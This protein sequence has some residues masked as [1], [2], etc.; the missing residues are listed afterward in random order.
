MLFQP[1]IIALLLASAL[2]VLALAASAPFALEVIRRWDITSGS[3]RQLQLERR[4]YLF[5]TLLSFVLALQLA[6]VLLF[7][8]NAEKMSGM[9]VGAM[10]AVGT[11]NVNAFGFPAL[12]AKIAVFFL[13]AMWLAINH[14]DSRARDYPLVRIK[15]ALLLALAPLLAASAWIELQY[16]LG[17][18]A[19][20]IT[21][22]CGSLF[23]EGSPTLAAEASAL[24][25][26]PAM[27]LFYGSLGVAIALAAWHG[28]GGGR[29]SA[30]VR[31]E[32]VE[33]QATSTGSGRAAST[34]SGQAASTRSGQAASTRSGQA[35][36]ALSLSGPGWAER[37]SGYALAAA[38]ALAFAAT[39]AGI[40]SFISLYIYEHPNHHCPFC[41]L[42]PEYG[43][44][45][46]W[47][48]VPL[49]A[50]TAAGLA[51]GAI[52]PF[53]RIASLR[54]IVPGFSRTLAAIAANGFALT[55]AIA[56]VMIW[57]SRLILLEH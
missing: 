51:V 52:Q 56:T 37:S 57:Q 8:F 11:L 34:R 20:V 19:D 26:L 44:Q 50:A 49:F 17:L 54:G 42:K 35:S 45:G 40:L 31:P 3:E 23:S 36:T 6:A 14:I 25:P 27:W 46:Y 7:V 55:A 24:S 41:I 10:C 38:S 1:A 4:T 18:K 16:F 32:P 43:Y 5:S 28:Y 47:L 21:S 22:C 15:Y 29:S 2:C 33:G 39:I 48:Y 53:A 9:F 13:A 12:N 30:S